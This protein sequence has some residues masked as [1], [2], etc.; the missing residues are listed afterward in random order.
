[1]SP[2]TRRHQTRKQSN[3][4]P[5]SALAMKGIEVMPHISGP[6]VPLRPIGAD[7]G[8]LC[9]CLFHFSDRLVDFGLS[10]LHVNSQSGC[11]SMSAGY[12]ALTSLRT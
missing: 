6:R 3:V 9:T 1:M 10:G 2:S 8:T 5:N 11:D 4:H 12:S 7:V